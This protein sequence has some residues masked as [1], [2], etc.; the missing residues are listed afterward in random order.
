MDK[1]IILGVVVLILLAGGVYFMFGK[2]PDGDSFSTELQEMTN[3]KPDNDGDEM[4]PPIDQTPSSTTSSASAQEVDGVKIFT[5]DGSNFKFE[6]NMIT[7]NKGDKIKVV[8]KNTGG[9]HDFVIDEFNVKTKQIGANAEDS[10][11]FTADKTGSFEF[12]CSVGNH[13]AMG[14]KGTLVVS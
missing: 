2:A 13:R 11:E 9:F 4:T 1:R 7:V 12:Y 14:M 6:P 5:V 8:F 10:V 3:R